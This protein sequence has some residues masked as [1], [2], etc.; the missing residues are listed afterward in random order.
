MKVLEK[1]IVLLAFAIAVC[2]GSGAAAIDLSQPNGTGTL[3]ITGITVEPTGVSYNFEG[4]IEGYGTAFITQFWRSVDS[5]RTRGPMEGEARV[6]GD[7]GTLAAAPLRGT[8][9]RSGT[10]AELY[11][12]DSVSNGDMNFVAWDVDFLTKK[13]SVRYFSLQR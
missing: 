2:F 7:D 3:T 6:L 8:F 10:T 9:R 12:T 1:M 5:A 4:P 11:F 13:V